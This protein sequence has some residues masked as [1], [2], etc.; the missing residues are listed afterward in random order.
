ML[1]R[2]WKIAQILTPG[3]PLLAHVPD[4]CNRPMSNSHHCLPRHFGMGL[5]LQWRL[6]FA[7]TLCIDQS[8]D[9]LPMPFT[10][11]FDRTKGLSAEAPGAECH[12]WLRTREL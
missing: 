10:R 8:D 3:K 11:I 2:Q 5:G 7:W 9:L 6:S 4:P 12:P 1:F